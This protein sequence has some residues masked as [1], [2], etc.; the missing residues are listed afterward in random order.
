[1][2]AEVQSAAA[3]PTS[4]AAEIIENA[5]DAMIL[6]SPDGMLRSANTAAHELFGYPSGAMVGLN[7][8]ELIPERFRERHREHRDEYV[9][10]PRRRAMGEHLETPAV[11]KDGSE[12][13][14][15]AALSAIPTPD[16]LLITCVVRQVTQDSVSERAQ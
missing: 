4:L 2:L 7:L 12:M 15:R 11:K 8:L 9:R 10:D 5:P 16:G 13:M 3:S 14:V 1:M 6:V